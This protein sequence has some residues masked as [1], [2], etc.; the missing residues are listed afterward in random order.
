MPNR[1]EEI[2]EEIDSDQELKAYVMLKLTTEIEDAADELA[3]EVTKRNPY[4]SP[5]ARGEN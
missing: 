2:W 4:Y 5:T 1:Y 3:E